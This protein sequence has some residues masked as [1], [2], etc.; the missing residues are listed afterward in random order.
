MQLLFKKLDDRAIIPKYQTEGS[1]GFDLHALEDIVIGR[2][3]TKVVRTGLACEIKLGY[4]EENMFM[5]ELQIRPR[6]GI[7]LKTS[8]RIANA[9]GTIDNDYRG[10]IGILIHN[11]GNISWRISAGERICQA[12]VCPIMRLPISVAEN[13]LSVTERGDGAYG[14][15]G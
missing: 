1:S 12:V 4:L 15:T 9:P 10:E 5:F 6:S 13:E 3:E 14:S 8:L 11:T 2:D 7:S